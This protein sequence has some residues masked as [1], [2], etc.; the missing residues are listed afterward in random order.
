MVSFE[1]AGGTGQDVNVT[2]SDDITTEAVVYDETNN[3]I[4]VESVTYNPG[5][6][7][8]IDGLKATVLE[9]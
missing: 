4:T 9:Y 2:Y 1:T 3:N 7:F 5:D 8:V 6:S